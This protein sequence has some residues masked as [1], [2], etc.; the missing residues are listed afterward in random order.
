MWD[1]LID[2][3]TYPDWNPFI[4]RLSG[5]ASVGARLAVTVQPP[6]RRAVTFKPTVL[7]ATPGRELRWLG[8]TV[9]PGLLDGEHGFVLEPKAGG[10]R[11]RQQETFSG[12]LV[13]LLSDLLADTERGFIDMNQALKHR[14][15]NRC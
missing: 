15:E 12:L 7:A 5:E 9:L 11:L 4:C 14:I 1:E 3:A 13:P 6:G 10:C 8:R 2:F